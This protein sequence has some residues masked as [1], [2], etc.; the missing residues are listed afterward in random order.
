MAT[1]GTQLKSCREEEG[2]SVVADGPFHTITWAGASQYEHFGR[3]QGRGAPFRWRRGC[4]RWSSLV[5]TS[6]TQLKSC[7]EEEG[8]SVVADGP[9]HTITW[10]GASQYG[11]FGRTQ[12]RGAPFRWRRGCARWSSLVA[13][14]GTQLKSC[15]EEEGRSVVADGPFHTITWAGASQY[16]TFGRTQ[17]RGAPFRW[18]RG[19]A[20][21]SSLV[22]DVRNA[23]EVVS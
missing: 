23:V 16:G 1:S 8:R 9:F 7:R 15:R 11:A 5:T 13:T 18:R 14:S 12:G 10:A 3:T 21:W 6:G 20:R 19:C 22:S 2:R 17:G 4:A